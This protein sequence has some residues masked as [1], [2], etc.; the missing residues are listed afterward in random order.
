VDAR[1]TWTFASRL[2]ECEFFVIRLFADGR[3]NAECV[4]AVLGR[5]AVGDKVEGVALHLV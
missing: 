2:S 4:E 5:R 1:E 3:T